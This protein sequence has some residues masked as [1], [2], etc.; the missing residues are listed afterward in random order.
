MGTE[1]FGGNG[2][3]LPAGNEASLWGDESVLELDSGDDGLILKYVKN[4]RT[5]QVKR[6]N[7]IVCKLYFNKTILL[8]KQVIFGLSGVS[9]S[10]E[11][12]RKMRTSSSRKM[13][14]RPV[15]PK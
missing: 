1:G 15:L 11:K 9:H 12:L 14:V 4:H 2:E 6:M 3:W 13:L 5:G 8:K 7:F 10:F